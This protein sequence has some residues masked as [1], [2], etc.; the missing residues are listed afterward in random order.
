MPDVFTLVTLREKAYLN[1]FSRKVTYKLT[2][3]AYGVEH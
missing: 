2:H 3:P 1:A